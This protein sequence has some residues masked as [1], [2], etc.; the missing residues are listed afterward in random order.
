V[1]T[2]AEA[3]A[4]EGFHVELPRLPGHGTT[5]EDMLPTGWGDWSAATDDAYQRLAGRAR[6]IV[7]AG[8]SMGAA[9]TLWIALRHPEV[10]GIVGI[11]PVTQP[12]PSEVREALDQVLAEGLEVLPAVGSD[13]RGRGGRSGAAR[14]TP[15]Q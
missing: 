12:W 3:F 14:S 2:L 4:A 6:G 13:R 1:R 7:V 10:V 8:L 9:L 15:G 5:V 11:N